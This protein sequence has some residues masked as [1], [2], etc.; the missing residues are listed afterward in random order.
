[1]TTLCV[2]TFVEKCMIERIEEKLDYL[3]ESVNRLSGLRGFGDNLLANIVGNILI[4]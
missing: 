4:R 2:T 3:I 1:M